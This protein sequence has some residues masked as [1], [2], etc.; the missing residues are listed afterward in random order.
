MN[1]AGIGKASPKAGTTN[2][3]RVRAKTDA[4]VHRALVEDPDVCPTNESFWDNAKVVMPARKEPITLRLDADLLAW[5]RRERGYQ[6][7]INAVLR[8]YMAAEL[9]KAG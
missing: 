6:T 2:W 4:A 3:K 1:D 9:R 8:T 7:R 5:L